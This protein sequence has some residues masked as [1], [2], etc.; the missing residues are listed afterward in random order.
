[1]AIPSGVIAIWSGSIGSIPAGW[2]LCDG[3]G[4]TPDLRDKFVP[5]AG[6]SYAVGATGGNVSHTHP[7]T[8]NLHSHGIPAGAAIAAGGPFGPAT[9]PIAASGTTNAANGLPPYYALAYIM[10]S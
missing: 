8:S 10:K 1:M 6:T 4:G 7:F 9:T 3:S 5:G 2:L